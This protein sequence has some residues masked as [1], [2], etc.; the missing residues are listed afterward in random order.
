ML[1]VVHSALELA[2]NSNTG[3]QSAMGRWRAMAQAV[4]VRDSSSS[5]CV[6]LTKVCICGPMH[7]SQQ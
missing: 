7:G 5:A 6:T 1:V 4:Q 2:A 3:E